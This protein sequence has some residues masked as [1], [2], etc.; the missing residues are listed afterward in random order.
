VPVHR[1]DVDG[2][3]VVEVAILFG[4]FTRPV[5]TLNSH[6]TWSTFGRIWKRYTYQAEDIRAE[7]GLGRVGI[8][9]QD[10]S[11]EQM[12]RRPWRILGYVLKMCAG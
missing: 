11:P 3:L 10:G 8:A 1:V 6:R 9:K 12:V 7:E 5:S 2:V 4:H